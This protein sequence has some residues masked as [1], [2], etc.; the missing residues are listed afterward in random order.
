MVALLKRGRRKAQ[1]E[2]I[3][4]DPSNGHPRTIAWPLVAD[5]SHTKVVGACEGFYKRDRNVLRSSLESSL[6]E[7]CIDINRLCNV[8]SSVRLQKQSGVAQYIESLR[9]GCQGCAVIKEFIIE[10]SET[11]GLIYDSKY[12]YNNFCKLWDRLYASVYD[13]AALRT[14]L[15][16]SSYPGE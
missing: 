14:R 3:G 6:C 8:T 5:G 16:V 12:D 13:P 4:P 1:L 2:S 15:V 10:L 9:E 7:V 11:H